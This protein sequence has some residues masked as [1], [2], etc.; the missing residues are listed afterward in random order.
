M[1]LRRVLIVTKRTA[2]E[3]YTVDQNDP[4]FAKLVAQ[5]DSLVQGPCEPQGITGR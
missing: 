4:R 2:Y 1:I 3:T 5:G